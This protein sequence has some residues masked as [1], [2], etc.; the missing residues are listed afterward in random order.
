LIYW[1]TS[2]VLKLY[3]A[4]PDST[5]YLGQAGQSTEPLLSSAVLRI[6]LHYALRQKELR[7]D[8]RSGAADRLTQQFE[9]DTAKGRW[10]LVAIGED[11]LTKANEL[12]RICYTHR[13]PVHLRTLDGVHLATAILANA[14]QVV[15]T[16]ARMRT[17]AAILGLP[18]FTP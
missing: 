11:V 13:P 9:A 14:Q 5:I 10:L 2:C 18:S 17:A 12:A 1:D 16:D 4:E 6:E 15:T 8:I 3:T 7:G